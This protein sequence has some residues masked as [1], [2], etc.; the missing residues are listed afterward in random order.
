MIVFASSV[1][2]PGSTCTR[3]LLRYYRT[4]KKYSQ[5]H[6]FQL[7]I[8]IIVNCHVCMR[9]LTRIA[10][11]ILVKTPRRISSFAVVTRTSFNVWFLGQDFSIHID[12]TRVYCKTFYCFILLNVTH[13]VNTINIYVLVALHLIII[14]Q[15]S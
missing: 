4:R 6:A 7:V 15:I 3:M 14:M 1:S 10:D 12:S 13:Q 8:A 5:K 11:A 9:V 2:L